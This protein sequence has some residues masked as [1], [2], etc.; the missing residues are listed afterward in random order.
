MIALTVKEL[1]CRDKPYISYGNEQ[2]R[3]YK[4]A[5]RRIT[6]ISSLVVLTGLAFI[7]KATACVF[8]NTTNG[9]IAQPSP[10]AGWVEAS[11]GI[12]GLNTGTAGTTI[13]NCSNASQL[14]IGVPTL[15]TAPGSFN[16]TIL[17]ALV[18]DGTNFTRSSS[19]GGTFDNSAW[20]Q[21]SITGLTIPANSNINLKIGII[22]GTNTNTQGVPSGTYQ[23]NVQLTAT[24]N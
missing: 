15:V 8:S 13:I 7:P 11:G 3:G 12:P 24:P 10:S 23:Y 19:T 16:P 6:C 5:M 4:G 14:T 17:E 18:Y 2:K 21:G 9:S 20:A 1:K 22:A